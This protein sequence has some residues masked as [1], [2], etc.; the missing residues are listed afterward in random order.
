MQTSSDQQHKI[1]SFIWL[2]LVVSVFLYAGIS[3]VIPAMEPSENMGTVFAALAFV[4]FFLGMVS[5]FVQ[6]F[7]LNKT[8]PIA[9][10]VDV[11]Q[12][13]ALAY[14]RYKTAMIVA[15]ALA[16]AMALMGVVIFVL[17]GDQNMLFGMAGVALVC[18]IATRPDQA[19][20]NAYVQAQKD[21]VGTTS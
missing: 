14:A 4:G 19:K 11:A 21:L 9:T 10:G 3:F 6:R 13:E 12:V 7:M 16:E 1:N 17:G 5:L 20:M 2:A 18:M 15:T 8:T